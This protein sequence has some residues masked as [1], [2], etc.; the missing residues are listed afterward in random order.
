MTILGLVLFRKKNRPG[1]C[2]G[3]WVETLH[4][5]RRCMQRLYSRALRPRHHELFRDDRSAVH[6]THEV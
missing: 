5:W 6:H 4:A 1:I 3:G 2:R